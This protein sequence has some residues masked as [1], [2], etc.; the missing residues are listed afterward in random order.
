MKSN[1]KPP[2]LPRAGI[3]ITNVLKIAYSYLAFL[4]NLKILQILKVL[5]TVA[6]ETTYTVVKSFIKIPIIEPKTT[7]ISKIF[8]PE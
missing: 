3:V 5:I 7:I 4:T 1:S 2:T 6:E 8:H